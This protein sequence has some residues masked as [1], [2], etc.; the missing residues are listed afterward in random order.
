[1]TSDEDKL[2]DALKKQGEKDDKK[3]KG[4][5]QKIKGRTGGKDGKGASGG[6]KGD[7]K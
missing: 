1:M 4:G 5:L 7:K 6:K 3:I 2:R